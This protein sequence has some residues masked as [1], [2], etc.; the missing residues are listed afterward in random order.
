MREYK[1]QV[2]GK[3]YPVIDSKADVNRAL[4]YRR[5]RR[6]LT[7]TGAVAPPQGTPRP[8]AV[9]DFPLPV[10]SRKEIFDAIRDSEREKRRLLDIKEYAQLPVLV[11]T[12]GYCWVFCVTKAI[13][14]CRALQG[15]KMVEL[16]PASVGA[17]VKNYRDVGGWPDEA[18]E[19]IVEVGICPAE[20]W[21][22]NGLDRSLDNEKSREARK[23]FCIDS[24]A[25]VD[26]GNL[27]QLFTAYLNGW[28]AG[29]GRAAFWGHATEGH[30]PVI[31]GPDELGELFDNSWPSFGTDGR[32]VLSERVARNFEGAVAVM[33][34]EP[35]Q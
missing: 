26:G 29:V 6:L 13:M 34:S 23:E 32:A 27:E 20:L 10:L 24:F 30:T 11:Q 28:P 3:V 21:P 12:L 15:K 4:N 2:T 31:L 14:T 1:D 33:S 5:S 19:K 16:S 22:L 9:K 18:V 25:G 8:R 35:L 17:L 7:K